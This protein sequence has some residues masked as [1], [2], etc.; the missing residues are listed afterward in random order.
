MDNQYEKSDSFTSKKSSR[1]W[2]GMALGDIFIS[3][4]SSG[5]FSLPFITVINN[6]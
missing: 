2:L 4:N 6:T 1:E 5:I 3:R